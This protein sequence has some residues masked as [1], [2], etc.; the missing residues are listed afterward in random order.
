MLLAFPSDD[1]VWDATLTMSNEDADYPV[2]NIQN[3][4]PSD[5]AKSTTT[6]TTVQIDISGGNQTV[7]GLFLG[8]TNFTTGALSSTAGAIGSFVFPSRTPDGKQRNGWLDLRGLSNV[9]EDHFE[10]ALSKTGS[11]AGELGRVCLV[12][13]WQAPKVLVEGAGTPPV[14][15]RIRPGQV[16]NISRG[17]VTNRRVSP[18]AA[19]RKLMASTHESDTR[20]ILDQLEA[21]CLGLNRGFL[22][23]PNEDSNDAWFA[24]CEMADLEWAQNYPDGVT[25]GMFP[26]RMTFLELSMGLPPALT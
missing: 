11:I 8:N 18:W 5:T 24:Q 10:I 26:M 22:L 15:G 13:A 4:D 2:E 25:D 12:T 20:D 19:I 6:S 9:T 3:N 17:G 16:E 21:E 7:V 14:F 1:L 23:V